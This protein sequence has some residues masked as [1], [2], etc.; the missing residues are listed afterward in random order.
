MQT[1]SPRMLGGLAGVFGMLAIA[2]PDAVDDLS[3][4]E[5]RVAP[6]RAP[7]SGNGSHHDLAKLE[8]EQE[9]DESERTES[10]VGLAYEHLP[11]VIRAD[12]GYGPPLPDL[13]TRFEPVD[14]VAAHAP[15][16][17]PRA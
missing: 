16:G 6:M 9:E 12:R 7:G 17:P 11:W 14:S 13:R 4:V 10:E 2:A 8:I 1:L 3:P 5:A 15:R